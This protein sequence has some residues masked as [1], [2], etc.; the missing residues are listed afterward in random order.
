MKQTKKKLHPIIPCAGALAALCAAYGLILYSEK[1][2]AGSELTDADQIYMTSFSDITAISWSPSESL[3]FEKEGDTWYYAGDHE[4]PLRQSLLTSLS[5]TLGEL[6]ASRE[7]QEPEE[8]SAY[9][10]DEPTASF[11]IT[12]ADGST[13]SVLIGSQVPGTGDENTGYETVTKEYY[14]A[15]DG[16]E[17][18]YTIGS[19]LVDTAEK[20]LYDFLQTE[21]LPYISGSDIFQLT[22]TKDGKTEE[23]SKGDEDEDGN[24]TWY[25]GSSDTPEADGLT[26]LDDSAPLNNLAEAVSGLSIQSCENYK[27]SEEELA[28]WGLTEPV[29]EITWTYKKGDTTDTITLAIGNATEDGASYYTKKDGSKAVNLVSADDVTK[30]LNAEY[31]SS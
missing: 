6:P 24:I 12:M 7:L 8:R 20:E 13:A 25:S 4:F 5:D 30:C 18:V 26:A 27:A 9:G 2:A 19:Y 28:A 22:V 14:A 10:L 21:S 16:Q 23:F 31:P 29:M 3:A 1:Q 17:N 15:L 11:Q